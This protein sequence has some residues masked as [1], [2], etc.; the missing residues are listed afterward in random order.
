M[1]LTLTVVEWYAQILCVRTLSRR[2][3]P[4]NARADHRHS[5]PHLDHHRRFLR[6][7]SRS[8]GISR[9]FWL[10]FC[11]EKRGHSSRRAD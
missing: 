3:H 2:I 11:L 10:Q 7:Y 1:W 9:R 8:C 5:N 6:R 4:N